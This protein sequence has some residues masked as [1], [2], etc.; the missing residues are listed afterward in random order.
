M[1]LIQLREN[2]LT[3]EF[4][5]RDST[6]V[7]YFGDIHNANILTVGINPSWQEFLT[8][9]QEPLSGLSRRFLH[10]SE[11]SGNKNPDA[12]SALTRM[13]DYFQRSPDVAYWPWFRP[14]QKLAEASGFSLIDGSAAHTDV[15]SCFA[16]FPAW[17][18]LEAN[19][20]QQFA[21]SGY[22]TFLEVLV[23]A[24][25]VKQVWVFGSRARRVMEEKSGLQFQPVKTPFDELPK[26]RSFRPVLSVADWT[27]TSGRELR[28]ISLGPYRNVPLSPLSYVEIATLPQYF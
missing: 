2:Q 27:P 6:P 5:C 26:V 19:V 9:G 24:P 18:K 25:R 7:L 17:S 28:V 23:E 1:E 16:T 21:E 4:V 10:E 14:I 3:S 11:M 15:L 13:N 8:K 22:E 12:D 20:T